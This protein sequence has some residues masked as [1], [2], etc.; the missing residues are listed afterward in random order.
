MSKRLLKLEVH[1]DN[2]LRNK[3]VEHVWPDIWAR[4]KWEHLD[5]LTIAP[6]KE[7]VGLL[8]DLSSL[9]VEP[10]GIVYVLNDS[11]VD[12]Y[13]NGRYQAEQELTKQELFEF[14]DRYERFIEQDARHHVV[15]VSPDLGSQINCHS[16][17][18]LVVYGS[19][20]DMIPILDRRG[21]R[22][23]EHPPFLEACAYNFHPEFDADQLQLLSEREWQFTPVEQEW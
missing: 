10:F 2:D 1:E 13:G 18:L 17:Q 3:T 22:E 23:V 4:W 12:D 16:D 15:V 20:E 5:C 9:L 11:R 8:K 21:M 14:L 6:S 7:H 19:T